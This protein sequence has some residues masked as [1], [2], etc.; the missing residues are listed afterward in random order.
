MM[1]LMHFILLTHY[2]R[3]NNQ[4]L[5][6]FICFLHFLA[7]VIVQHPKW[8][9]LCALGL[10]VELRSAFFDKLDEIQCFFLNVERLPWNPTEAFKE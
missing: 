1:S 2:L 4:S 8:A 9:L 10:D 6:Y 5:R 7:I 3:R